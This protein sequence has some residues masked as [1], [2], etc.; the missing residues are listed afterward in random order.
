MNRKNVI[1]L[2]IDGGRLDRALSSTVFNRLKNNSAFF[3]QSVTYGP[4]TIAAMHAVFS[5][6]YGNRTGTDSYWSTFKFKKDKFKTLTEYLHDLEYYTLAD[7][8]NEL[9]IPKQGFDKFLIHDELKDDLTSRHCN[10][11]EEMSKMNSEGK[12]FFLYQ[13]YSNIHTGIMNEVLKVYDNFS[14]EYFSNKEKNEQR[15][16]KLF[17]DAEIYLETILQ[18]IKT[19]ELDKNSLILIM[20]DHGISVGEK[21]GERAYG[22]FCYDYTLRTFTYFVYPEIKPI[23]IKQQVRTIDFMPT[24]L[25]YLNIPLS[26]KFEKID[27]ESLLSLIN[28][29]SI[30]EKLAF[31]E[32][33]NPLK[34]NR[35]PENPNTKSIRS[36]KW[37]FIFNEYD[38]SKELY[39]LE[40]D[41]SEESNLIGKNLEIENILW[42]EI[43]NYL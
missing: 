27:G 20:S 28:G 6:T 15:Y 3:S 26:E 41:P 23:E 35:P 7:V 37:K 29:N 13:Q 8:V 32:T 19:L 36:S 14:D 43:Q 10:Y 21:I 9:V 30:E 11:L 38:G 42:K 4:H 1:I 22:A 24:I 17:A 33:G 34:D 31:S 39:D 5:G 40:S 16:D 25:D 12:N 18:H 2:M